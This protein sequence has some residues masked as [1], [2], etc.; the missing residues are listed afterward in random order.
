MPEPEMTLAEVAGR[1]KM[2]EL[3]L[4]RFLNR[5]GFRAIQAGNRSLLFTEADYKTNPPTSGNHYPEWY[6]DGVYAAQCSGMDAARYAQ[7]W[8]EGKWEFDSR[9]R[10]E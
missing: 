1:L 8:Q 4:R 2:A 5:I 10:K 3:T 9:T 7:G 6:Q